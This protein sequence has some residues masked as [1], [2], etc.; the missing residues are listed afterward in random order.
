MDEHKVLTRFF[1]AFVAIISAIY[2]DG[3]YRM[4]LGDFL[5]HIDAQERL[6]NRERAILGQYGLTP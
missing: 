2:D 1:D 6:R 3:S 4:S 5:E